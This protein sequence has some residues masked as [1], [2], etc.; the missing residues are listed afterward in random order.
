MFHFFLR[1][2]YISFES[3][4]DFDW[5]MVRLLFILIGFWI[6][7]NRNV[8]ILLKKNILSNWQLGKLFFRLK[9]KCKYC[10]FFNVLTD[11]ETVFSWINYI[12]D[13]WIEKYAI[14]S[15]KNVLFRYITFFKLWL[16]INC[17]YLSAFSYFRWSGINRTENLHFE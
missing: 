11:S 6:F 16:I 14:K 7:V 9:G 17:F 3:K 2:N 4:K 15:H 8:Y 5:F 10:N 13:K 12:R 1:I